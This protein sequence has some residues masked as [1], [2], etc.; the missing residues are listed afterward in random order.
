MVSSI[1]IHYCL[2]PR[3]ERVDSLVKLTKLT[4][5]LKLSLSV[6][7]DETI[8]KS[9]YPDMPPLKKMDFVYE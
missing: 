8:Y 4:H 9:S 1:V 3:K 5:Y 6:A 2:Y 7:Y